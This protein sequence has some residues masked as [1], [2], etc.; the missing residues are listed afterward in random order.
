M[1]RL[2]CALRLAAGC[3]TPGAATDP[4]L[5]IGTA[6]V[7]ITPPLGYRMAGYF[8]ERLNTGTKDPLKAKAIVFEQGS[9]RAALVFCDLIGVPSNL[10]SKARQDAE[11]ATG[12]PAANISI[13]ATHSHTGPLFYGG[14]A[15]ILHERAEAAKGKDPQ[16]FDF[17]ALLADRLV[18]AIQHA[19]SRT[20][21]ASLWGG[22]AEETEL[23]FNRRFL[24]KDGSVRTNPGSLNPE[25]VK[26]TGPIDPDLS[27]LAVHRE[28][29]IL[30][31]LTVFALHCD[32]TGGTEY[33]ADY[34]GHLERELRASWGDG[35]ISLFGA[36]TCGNINHL[37]VS[38]KE[39]RSAREIGVRL[40]QDVLAALPNLKPLTPSLSMRS[41]RV[42]CPAQRR[43]P[44]E[45]ARARADL[46]K[47][48]SKDLPFLDQVRI[49]T[50]LNLQDLPPAL[51][52]EV[53]VLRLSGDTAIVLLPG[54]VFVE[55][56][57]A[58]KRGS[59]FGRTIVIEL[60]NEN[61]AYIPTRAAFAQGAYEV[62]NSRI[63]PGGGERLV[64]E[65]LRLLQE[66]VDAKS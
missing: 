15:R 20:Q 64:E 58:I 49:V 5:R 57:Q 2:L 19:A 50:T 17:S 44:E 60:A 29:R 59:P 13:A 56:G 52:L 48:G 54:E 45:V 35:L 40:G 25:I 55:L 6:E 11:R 16:D 63:A 33:S 1:R 41:A 10:T 8:Y 22:R 4:A 39:R 27:I 30:A 21:P 34:P 62:E 47:V 61:C 36:G 28:E 42:D 24:M 18:M 14:M 65:A 66:L 53:Q 9:Q 37:D 12:I 23:S 38:R 31:A 7:D 43:T 46:A 51:P 3:A 32:T 26:T